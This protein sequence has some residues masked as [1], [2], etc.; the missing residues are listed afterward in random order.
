MAIERIDKRFSAERLAKAG[1]SLLDASTLC[2][3]STVTPSGRAHVNTAYFAWSPSLDIVWLSAPEARHS[4]NLEANASAAV[5]VYDSAQ[6]WGQPDRGIQLFGTARLTRGA[7]AR[8]AEAL[9]GARFP[10][11]PSTDLS[12]Y[13]L[14]RLR[15]TRIKLFD[16]R[17]LGTALFVTAV[18]RRGRL[19]W[20]TTERYVSHA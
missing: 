16:E 8:E 6:T 7:A 11:F 15:P 17:A 4:R 10:D 13:R 2:A 18:V 1:R 9:Y 3:I 19:M 20:R 5:S 12:E 14:Y